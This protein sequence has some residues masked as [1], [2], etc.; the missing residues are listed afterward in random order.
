MN[1]TELGRDCA[2]A[3]PKVH[4]W[5]NLLETSH[6]LVRLPAFAVNRTK[7]LIK[8]PKSYWCDTGLALHRSGGE[9]GGAHLENLVLHDLAAWRDARTERAELSYWRTAAGEAVD[10]VV[11]EGGR[12]LPIE[13]KSAARPRLADA[14]ALRSFR[15]EYGAKARHGQLLHTGSKIER[16]APDVLAVPWWRAI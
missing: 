6:L 14:A 2:V 10:L 4:R 5:L 11:E 7:R 12:L 16:L 13:I 1:R 3:Q 9:P 15:A 8:A